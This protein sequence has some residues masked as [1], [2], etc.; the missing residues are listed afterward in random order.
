MGCGLSELTGKSMNINFTLT[1]LKWL[2]PVDMTPKHK[3]EIMAK[4]G[5]CNVQSAL[6]C[7]NSNTAKSTQLSHGFIK[8]AK[9]SQVWDTT[10]L[11][12]VLYF[13]KA[14]TVKLTAVL[15]ISS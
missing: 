14:G 9:I 8:V 13:H 7:F 2:M 6:S 4:F 1:L 5:R 3:S 10:K 11:C 15:T 12:Y